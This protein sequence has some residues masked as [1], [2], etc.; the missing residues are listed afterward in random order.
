MAE[1]F[2]WLQNTGL[3]TGIRQSDVWF[4]VI[5]GTHI[6][7]LALSVGLILMLDLRLLGVS[8]RGVPVSGVMESAMT[9]ALP[10]FVIMFATGILLFVA[11]ADKAWINRYLQIKMVLL[12]ILAS[13]AL[14]YQRKY[15][16][17]MDQW[18]R[19]GKIPGGAR[20]VGLISLVLWGA[21]ICCGRL[22]AYEI[23][24]KSVV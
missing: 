18:E 24:R 22:M 2:H 13:N 21:V 6:M 4:P 19:D 15:F 17:V 9:W 3:A 16:P 8:F 12:V 1:F 11:Q 23:D 5:E 14:F 20:T 7:A 10:G